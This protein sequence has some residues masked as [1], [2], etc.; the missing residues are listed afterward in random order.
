MRNHLKRLHW[1]VYPI[2]GAIL[3]GLVWDMVYP[4]A[5]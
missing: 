4:F 1:S 3:L 2:A 5:D